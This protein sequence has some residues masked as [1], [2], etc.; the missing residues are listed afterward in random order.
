MK[1]LAAAL[2]GSIRNVTTSSHKSPN[3]VKNA[4][5]IG[6]NHPVATPLLNSAQRKRWLLFLI[7]LCAE[8]I[9]SSEVL[10]SVLFFSCLVGALAAPSPAGVLLPPLWSARPQQAAKAGPASAGDLPVQRPPSGKSPLL[11]SPLIPSPLISSPLLNIFSL[12]DF[13]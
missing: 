1:S 13:R 9:M 4:K 8:G 10:V 5:R 3:N 6:V 7:T 12:H 11:S 2:N